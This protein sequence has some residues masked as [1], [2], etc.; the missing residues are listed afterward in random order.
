MGRV[1]NKVALITGAARGQGRSHAIRLAEEGADIIAVDVCADVGSVPYPLGTVDELNETAAMVEKTGRRVMTRVLDVRSQ[2]AMDEV[3]SD[4]VSEFGHVDIVSANAAIV[5]FGLSWELSEAAW[6]DTID[7]NLTGV[8][9]T[10]KAVAPAMIAAGRGGSIVLTSSTGG[11]RGRPNVAA[12]AASKHGMVGLMR[13]LANELAPYSIRVN[14]LHPTNVSTPMF[15]NEPTRR[16]FRP[17][18]ENPTQEDQAVAGREM[19]GLP[20]PWVDPIDVSNALLWLASD[21]ARYITGVTL[22]IDAGML[23]K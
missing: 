15:F 21:E 1:E 19:N 23:I 8:W 13:S 2:A 14:S 7:I 3:V 11:L 18:L 22:P 20:I 6:Q 17:D 9:H 10:T 5:N 4:A 12:Y 16:L